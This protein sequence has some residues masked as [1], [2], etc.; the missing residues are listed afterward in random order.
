[1]GNAFPAIEF[2][3]PSLDLREKHQALDG[4]VNGRIRR[5]FP[6][7]LDHSVARICGRHFDLIVAPI[8][9]DAVN[10][11]SDCCLWA[12][13]AQRPAL[14]RGALDRKGA[15]GSSALLAGVVHSGANGA[16]SN[17]TILNQTSRSISAFMRHQVDVNRRTKK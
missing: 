9:F 3:K 1:M 7:G 2:C 17:G 8:V 14:S 16:L 6:Q 4:I 15:A 12:L 11:V 10:F 13:S 5:E